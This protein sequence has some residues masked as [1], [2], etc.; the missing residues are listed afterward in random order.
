[1]GLVDQLVDPASLEAVAVEAAAALA[2]GSLKPKRRPKSMVNRFIEDTPMGRAIVWKKVH[3]SFVPHVLLDHGYL[4]V[5][6]IMVS[7]I[8]LESGLSL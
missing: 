6:D 3:T 4:V 5:W 2:A 1:M 7:V 8:I